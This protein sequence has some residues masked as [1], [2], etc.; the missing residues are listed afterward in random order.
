M[1]GLFIVGDVASTAAPEPVVFDICEVLICP[2]LLPSGIPAQV[3]GVPPATL[4]Q[5]AMPFTDAP[6]F[7]SMSP[8]DQVSVVGATEDYVGTCISGPN[9]GV[10]KVSAVAVE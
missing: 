2:L 9:V 6:E 4:T 7:C 10:K 5:A 8:C 1:M 3:P